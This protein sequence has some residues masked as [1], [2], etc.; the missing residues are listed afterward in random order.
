MAAFVAVF[1]AAAP[2]L[3]QTAPA[4]APQAPSAP[5]QSSLEVG[6]MQ[7]GSAADLEVEGIDI[8]VTA[9]SVVY[10]YLLKNAGDREL[11][12]T[13]SVAMPE[14]QASA[15]GSQTWV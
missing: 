14:L 6:A 10:S 11:N 9:G 4:N 1:V 15:D 12:L 3:A 2:A 8:N 5:E 13:A 7:I